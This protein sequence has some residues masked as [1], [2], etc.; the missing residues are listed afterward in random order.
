M[1]SKPV[2]IRAFKHNKLVYRSYEKCE[3][4]MINDKY[5]C[6]DCQYC[7]VQHRKFVEKYHRIANLKSVINFPVLWFFPKNKWFNILVKKKKNKKPEIYINI[8]NP[9]VYK[10]NNIDYTDYDLDYE[11]KKDISGNDYI[12]KELDMDEY[13]ENAKKFK[14]D[15]ALKEQIKKAVDEV[16]LF[17]D[18]KEFLFYFEKF[19]NYD[20]KK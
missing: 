3:I 16:K 13:I 6:V 2:K 4:I 8:A 18:K 1:L 14:Y 11:I 10:N 7:Y 5:I 9:F 17:F 19:K 15:D 12:I 20:F